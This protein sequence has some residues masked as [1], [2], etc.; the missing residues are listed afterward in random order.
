MSPLLHGILLVLRRLAALFDASQKQHEICRNVTLGPL[1][2]KLA[3]LR[4]WCHF[5]EPAAR[6]T[7]CLKV[8]SCEL[9]RLLQKV[10]QWLEISLVNLEP[11]Q[12]VRVVYNSPERPD[13]TDPL[14]VL[15]HRLADLLRLPM[16]HQ[17]KVLSHQQPEAAGHLRLY[18]STMPDDS[19]PRFSK[20]AGHPSDVHAFLS[21]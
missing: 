13:P 15:T 10:N 20:F 14:S 9:E 8:Q 12:S 7:L 21:S 18:D 2:Q 4:C 1:V 6:M 16:P 19:K 3:R 11:L 5:C 17:Q